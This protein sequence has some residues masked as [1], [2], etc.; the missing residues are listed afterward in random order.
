MIPVNDLKR[1][2]ALHASEYEAKALEILRSGWYVL[3]K[4][5]SLF[6]SRFAEMLGSKY[7]IGID[8]GL[9]AISLG[10]EALG[11]GSNDE[12]I[13][14]SNTYIA[15]M[16]GVTHNNARLVLVE[17]DEYYNID[18]S[19]IE[20]AITTK[21]KAILIT[22]LYGQ[23]S[24]MNK[25]KKICGDR[26]L[27]LL[28][29]C[30]QS[31]FSKYNSKN[32]GTFGVMGFFSFYPT[33]NLGAFGDAGA[34]VTDDP[35]LDKKLKILRN[36]GSEKRYINSV[37]GYNCRLD[38]LQAG[39]LNIKL[40]Y[41]NELNKE[42]NTIA[43]RY[44]EEIRNDNIVLPR[45]RKN[46][47]SVWH[48]F[49]IKT[50]DRNQFRAFLSQ[51]GINTDVHY[52]IPVHLSAAYSFYGWKKGDFPIAEEFSNE[53]VSL[54]MFNGMINQEVDTVIRAVNEYGKNS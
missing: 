25:I 2:Y 1:S 45:V 22:H 37:V 38:E 27:F 4:E 5:V 16:L 21:T 28:E 12:V 13:V 32:T 40:A 34:I 48:Q 36:Y 50:K 47:S 33:K 35:I 51:K 46:A 41:I 43:K 49:V 8:N 31:H 52:P 24:N 19:K 44:L 42:R 3:G 9:N 39:L 6:E 18:A 30:A 26:K 29:D 54:P 53:V 20:E 15:T 14:Q 10:I 7:A 23:S 11:I 17:P